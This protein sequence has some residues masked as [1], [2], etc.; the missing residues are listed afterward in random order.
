MQNSKFIIVSDDYAF[1]QRSKA[2]AHSCGVSVEVFSTSEWENANA[3][4]S[5]TTV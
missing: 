3:I 5:Q 2:F 4:N 1:I